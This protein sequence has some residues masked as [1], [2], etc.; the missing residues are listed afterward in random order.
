MIYKSYIEGN[1][2]QGIE[3]F[4]LQLSNTVNVDLKITNKTGFFF[5]RYYFEVQGHFN[6][7]N[8]FN[9]LLQAY[10]DEYNK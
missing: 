4:L 2:L 5:R 10:I 3:D 9:S 8:R 6:N 7:I 1:S